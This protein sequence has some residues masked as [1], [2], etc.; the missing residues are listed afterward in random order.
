MT[1][2]MYRIQNNQLIMQD[3]ELG[4]NL[5]LAFS[6]PM[7]P[8]DLS[9]E[10]VLQDGHLLVVERDMQKMLRAAFLTCDGKR[11][12]QCRLYYPSGNVEADMYYQM[13]KLHGPSFFYGENGEV[14]SRTFFCEGKREG[15][16]YFY[17][18]SGKVSS[19]QRFKEGRWHEMQ[20]YFYEDGIVKSLLP[21]SLGKLHGEVRLFWEGGK[22]KRKTSYQQGLREGK[23]QLWNEKGVLIDEAEYKSGQPCGTHRYYFHSGKVKEEWVYHTPTR[24]DRKEWNE[25]GKLVVEGLWAPDMSYTEKSFLE[26]HGAQVRKGYWNGNKLCWK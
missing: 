9:R 2:E 13:D 18:L 24:Y 23:D 7:L 14:L 5:T 12:G 26:T 11:H 17:Y 8:K 6:L 19:V 21:Y 16:V 3:P 20:E 15:K 1:Q 10:K 4:L 25:E 22:T